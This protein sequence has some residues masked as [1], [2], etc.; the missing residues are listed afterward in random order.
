MNFIFVALGGAVGAM[1]RYAVSLIP[2]KTEFPFLTLFTNIAGAVLIGFVAGMAESGSSL[3]PQS[4]LFWKTGVCG[5]FTTF[6]TFSLE[7]WTLLEHRSYAAAGGYAVLSV[8]CCV[9]GIV[10]GRKLAMLVQ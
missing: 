3:S 8:V 1:S 4:L 5:G 2:L 9:F 10:C 7:T 6:S